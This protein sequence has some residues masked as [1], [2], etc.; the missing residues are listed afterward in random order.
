MESRLL[1]CCVLYNGALVTV[2]FT[3]QNTHS[4]KPN[5][6]RKLR[7][8]IISKG[9]TVDRVVHVGIKNDDLWTEFEFKIPLLARGENR[10]TMV[11][12]LRLQLAA[13]PGFH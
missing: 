11:H 13:R 5:Y 4:L 10:V 6:I 12:C 9:V 3:I 2:Q 7:E 8:A 1:R